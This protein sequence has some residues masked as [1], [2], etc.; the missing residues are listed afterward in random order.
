MYFWFDSFFRHQALNLLGDN[1]H[2]K[3]GRYLVQPEH[4]SEFDFGYCHMSLFDNTTVLGRI[5]V[6]F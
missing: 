6:D 3:D 2:M 5:P 4:F 1:R